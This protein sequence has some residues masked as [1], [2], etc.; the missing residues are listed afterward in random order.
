MK[1]GIPLYN[2]PYG[3]KDSQRISSIRALCHTAGRTGFALC[4]GVY[5]CRAETRQSHDAQ[6]FGCFSLE[7]I[8]ESPVPDPAAMADGRDVCTFSCGRRLCFSLSACP[9]DCCGPVYCCTYLRKTPLPIPVRS[10]YMYHC[11][12]ACDE[13]GPVFGGCLGGNC[14]RDPLRCSCLSLPVLWEQDCRDADRCDHDPHR[15]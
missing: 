3:R 2:Y 8:A 14:S 1:Y 6:P 9:G 5:C 7:Y 10:R 4:G 15:D 11:G 12:C 13:R